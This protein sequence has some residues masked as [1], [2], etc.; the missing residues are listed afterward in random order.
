MKVAY[1]R[2]STQEQ[3]EQRQL[4]QMDKIGVDRIYMEKVSGR[5]TDREQLKAMLDFVR[6]GDTV[7]VSDF[8]RLSRSA[9]DLL[10]II[11]TLEN[12][13][14]RL[15]SLKE[16]LDT[17]TATGRLMITMIGA[18]NAFERENLM[19]RQREGI[20]IAVREPKYKGRR[21]KE[22][23]G[24]DEIY[25]AWKNN[26]TTAAAACRLLKISRSTFYRH[27]QDYEKDYIQDN[28]KDHK[29]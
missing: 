3:N 29:E 1:V 16:D 19:E 4:E 6:E 28:E 15:I 20:A 9:R 25:R 21:K 11:E 24:F 2:V 12:K 10:S 5:N 22:L 13:K 8:S 14:V 26:E 27:V 18:I 17:S 7:Y 23:E